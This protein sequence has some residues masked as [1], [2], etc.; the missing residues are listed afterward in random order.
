[1]SEIYEKEID[2]KVVR[3]DGKK[4]D[5]DGK[6]IAL[7]IKKG[8]D[9]VNRSTEISKYNEEDINKVYKNV[10][11]KIQKVQDD[12]IKIEKIQ[13]LIEESLKENNYLDVYNSFSSYREKRAYSRQI[14]FDEKKQHKFLKAIEDLGLKTNSNINKSAM[15][16]MIEYGKT[17]SKEF[18]KSYLLKKKYLDACENGEIYIQ[19][20]DYYATGT[21]DSS[22]IDLDKVIYEGC[23]KINGE[24]LAEPKD[25]MEY[26]MYVA[27]IIKA[28]QV[29]QHGEQ[30]IPLF[31][32]Y[33]KDSVVKTFKNYFKELVYNY[34]ELTDF[35]K[36]VA[37]NGIEREIEKINT[38]EFNVEIFF[39]F[40]RESEE[41]K[42]LFKM[43]YSKS[44]LKTKK[45]IDESME[46]L[47]KTLNTYSK[48]TTL[49][50]GTNMEVEGKL[51]SNSILKAIEEN[52]NNNKVFV[53]LKVKDGVN[54]QP[55]DKNY[56]LL[57]RVCEL[58]E[59]N[60]TMIGIA[61]LDSNYN[62]KIYKGEAKTEVA[63]NNFGARICE[64]IIDENKAIIPGRVNLSTTYINLP[65]LG[66]K[67][68]KI[69]NNKADLKGFYNELEEKIELSKDQLLDRFDNQCTK[70]VCNFPFL[71]GDGALIDS[72]RIKE[73]DS[74]RKS[75]KHGNLCI[76]VIGL[77]ECLLA[78]LG[79]HQGESAESQK[80][81]LEI[82]EFIKKKCDEYSQKYNLNFC[83][84]ASCDKNMYGKF[85]KL[86]KA[87]YGNISNITDKKTYTESFHLPENCKIQPEEKIKIEAPYHK[88]T[89]GGHIIYIRG[90]DNKDIL[91][92]I[93]LMK[94]NN[95]GY[96]KIN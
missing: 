26:V 35:D 5:F 72:E 21:T 39:R 61:F 83:V 73:D 85:I 50:I 19:K 88:L 70:R 49:N 91:K 11:N 2:K 22:Q 40:C 10:L 24:C 36:F 84:T 62:K 43:A 55:K 7:A 3:R 64:N 95:I 6:K 58:I 59:K 78:M 90:K 76:G 94:E 80:L 4:V 82:I 14:F 20:M 46:L 37:M 28:T 66:I 8:F 89:S 60:N 93:K 31:D 41:L 51:V 69:N 77:A 48:E 13:D 57:E 96:A 29:E 52:K 34:L 56:D 12:K 33:L 65:R 32:Y 53:I 1:M 42:R 71:I 18:T 75:L 23:L 16:V 17:I 27:L 67:Y 54:L 25:I 44:I 47:V 9:S 92:I 38:I 86:D 30:S 87:I 81:G 63:Y 79:K 74:L 15:D 68:G 45:L